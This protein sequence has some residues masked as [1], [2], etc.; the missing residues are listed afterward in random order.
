M[1]KCTWD[2]VQRTG[3]THLTRSAKSRVLIF[4]SRRLR[5]LIRAKLESSSSASTSGLQ[6]HLTSD[7]TKSGLSPS[8]KKR[9]LN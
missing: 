4:G 9:V 1:P 7:R 6:Q 2:R 5:W 8:G 3:G